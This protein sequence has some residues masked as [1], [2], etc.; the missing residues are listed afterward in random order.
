MTEYRYEKV[1]AALDETVDIPEDAIGVTTTTFGGA[2][3]PEVF[4]ARYLV[5]VEGDDA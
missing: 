2:D 3:L 5:P 1:S 4:T